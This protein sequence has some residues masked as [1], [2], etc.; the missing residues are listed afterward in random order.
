MKARKASK[1]KKAMHLEEG[2]VAVM[3]PGS[4]VEQLRRME[5]GEFPDPI[6]LQM[7]INFIHK[8]RA[9]FSKA[10][11]KTREGIELDVDDKGVQWGDIAIYRGY[12]EPPE[13]LQ[14]VAH[15][16]L[17]GVLG[18]QHLFLFTDMLVGGN[19]R[20]FIDVRH[21]PDR[22]F[23]VVQGIHDETD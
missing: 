8:S 14:E 4:V 10:T 19:P 6:K 20:E 16:S 13:E 2:C 9:S 1:K 17:E 5:L 7:A 15:E 12:H 18:P 11:L 21:V 23:E 3:L 22:V